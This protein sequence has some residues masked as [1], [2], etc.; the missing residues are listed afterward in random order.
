MNPATRTSTPYT[1]DIREWVQQNKH[2]GAA[3]VASE[4]QRDQLNRWRSGE[5]VPAEEYLQLLSEV[6]PASPTEHILALIETEIR[7][8]RE[9]GEAPSAA[10]FIARFTPHAERLLA[11]F[12]QAN[13][14]EAAATKATMMSGVSTRITMGFAGDAATPSD[15]DYEVLRE[16]GRG[17]MGVVYEAR[18]QRLGR[19]VAL[20][21]ARL[22]GAD[23]DEARTRF[24]SEARIAARLEH[25]GVVPVHELVTPPDSDPFYTMKLVRGRTFA[26]AIEDF[27]S[28]KRASSEQIVARRRLLETYLAICRTMAFAHSKSVI[29]RDL[30][31][32]N[33]VIGEFGETVILDWGLAKVLRTEETTSRGPGLFSA[34]PELTV[35]GT[36]MG[37]PAYMSPEQAAGRPDVDERADIYALGAILYHIITGQY[38]HRGRGQAMLQDI[39]EG[40]LIPPSAIASDVA[41]PLEAICLKSMAKFRED[42]YTG[43]QNLADDV[44][45][46]LAG[47]PVSVYRERWPERLSR[48]TRRHRTLVTAAGVAAVL[49]VVGVAAAFSLHQR[50]EYERREQASRF[51]SE[52]Q[53]KQLQFESEQSQEKQRQDFAEQRRREQDRQDRVERATSSEKLGRAEMLSGRFRSAEKFFGQ[54]SALVRGIPGLEPRVARLEEMR[55]RSR[56]IADFYRVKDRADSIS[57]G[58]SPAGSETDPEVIASCERALQGFGVLRQSEGKWWERLPNDELGEK[59][60]ARLAEDTTSL[61]VL[62][63]V[64]RIKHGATGFSLEEFKEARRLL[65]PVQRY[66]HYLELQQQARGQKPL[67]PGSSADVLEL[68]LGV[69]LGEQST[70]KQPL[71]LIPRSADDAYFIGVA[72]WFLVWAEEGAGKEG[73]F[74]RMLRGIFRNTLRLSGLD[75]ENPKAA[76]ERFFR[77]AIAMY[78][79]HYWAHWSLGLVRLTANDWP[80]AEEA[81]NAC[82]AIRPDQV[83]AY[84]NRFRAV[85][86]QAM[87]YRAMWATH[88]DA[89]FFRTLASNIA[90]A[91]IQRNR[92]IVLRRALDGLDSAPQTFQTSSM[93]RR[94]RY[95]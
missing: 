24:L 70:L 41:R 14:F 68:F 32:A 45:R 3:S 16:L 59:Q 79:E 61:M 23:S 25:P 74:L 91:S 57:A 72:Q 78:P 81:F 18:E 31:P 95:L 71:T 83:S 77:M 42:R 56:Q 93:I 94:Q 20:K 85:Y 89:G 35:S 52:Q 80:G 49:S 2:L 51:E 66:Y 43:A 11:I 92:T 34:S 33:V 15:V 86:Q 36:V 48:W 55:E 38:P 67:P 8:R 30:K 4:L 53:R 17:G 73:E 5:R 64:W 9:L 40:E 19:V 54:G 37:T 27:H 50:A 39:R 13:S 76:S 6:A 47:E 44:E 26:D 63:A 88:Q 12:G 46:F 82:I 10:E 75:T 58:T 69:L 29:H 87:V 21:T 65:V 84:T 7:V 28:S 60:K 22:D 62:L 1:P 90:H